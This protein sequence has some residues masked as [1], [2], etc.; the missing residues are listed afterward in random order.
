MAKAPKATSIAKTATKAVADP[1][2]TQRVWPNGKPGQSILNR[3]TQD[4]LTALHNSVAKKPVKAFKSIESARAAVDKLLGDDAIKVV[5]SGGQGLEIVDVQHVT[6]KSD[7]LQ[8]AILKGLQSR[9]GI[10]H[11]S[12]RDAGAKLGYSPRQNYYTR[13]RQIG[14]SAGLAVTKDGDAYRAA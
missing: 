6:G 11:A 2:P 12:V 7:A 3:A 10:T 14:E 1:V 4:E 5:A 13:I 8:A 9:N